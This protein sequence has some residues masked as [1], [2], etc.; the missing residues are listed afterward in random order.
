MIKLETHAHCLYGSRCA[1]V[2][3]E[4][5][6]DEY[7]KEGYGGVV[8]TNHYSMHSYSS[9]PGNSKKEKLDFYFSLADNLKSVGEKQN[10]KVYFGCEVLAF[11]PYGGF[12]EYM[13]YGFKK[14]FLYDSPLLYTL[15]QQELFALAEKNHLFMYQTH[16]FRERVAVGDPN[17]MHGAE[18][19]NGHVGHIENNELADKFCEKYSLIKMSGTDYHDSGQPITGG[20]F[21]PENLADES[22]LAE[23]I[24]NNKVKLICD[25]EKYFNNHE[26]L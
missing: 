26:K 2:P 3:A 8:I 13:L 10:F 6:V 21:V 16:P 9:Y 18:S 11:S 1:S 23:Y 25:T 7:K 15:T 19:F 17:F 22:A 20:I 14:S 12:S 4:V 5:L 24:M